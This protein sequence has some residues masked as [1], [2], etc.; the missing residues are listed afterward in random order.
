MLRTDLNSWSLQELHEDS[1]SPSEQSA[2]PSQTQRS[3]M[4]AWSPAQWN[5]P[6]RHSPSSPVTARLRQTAGS[7]ESGN[8]SQS[9]TLA[10]GSAERT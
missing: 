3:G 10:S 9:S 6:L 7:F 5:S 8:L 1:S 2:R 4:Q